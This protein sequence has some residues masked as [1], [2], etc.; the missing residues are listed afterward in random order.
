MDSTNNPLVSICCLC[1]NHEP[2]IR[3]CLEGFMM[4]MTNFAFE[5]LIHDDAST[6]KSAEIIREYEAKYPDIIKP[7]YQT[8]NQYSKGVGVTRVFQ[9]PRSKGKYI[10]L[11]EGDDYWTDPY[12]L[13]KQVDFLEANPDYTFC[14]HDAFI[15]NQNTGEKKERIGNRV[16]EK[17][18]NLHSVILENNFPTASLVFRNVFDWSKMPEWF[19]KTAKGDYA[20][21]VLLAEKGLGKYIPDVMSVYRV[22]DGGVWSGVK[23]R[24]YHINEDIKFYNLLYEYFTKEDIRKAIHIKRAKAY[25]NLGINRMRDGKL[26]SGL[27]QILSHWNYTKDKRFSTSLR[28]IA[29]AAKTGVYFRLSKQQ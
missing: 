1:Y 25:Q 3:E 27:L 18:V 13:Q 26:F 4:Q 12:K 6:D 14:F 22:H 29:S 24:S 20:L 10:A 11:C 2:Y 21:V 16:I 9:Y 5:V 8:E 17:S 28:K 23:Q 7:I 15:L 19:S